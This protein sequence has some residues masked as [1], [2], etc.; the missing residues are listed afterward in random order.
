[1]FSQARVK[2]SV[3]GG[4]GACVARGVFMA[5]GMHGR[6]MHGGGH[7]WQEGGAWQGA[8]VAGGVCGG[9]HAW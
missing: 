9:V 7:A 8:W 6:G 2:N 1:M 3:H 5:G 4:G